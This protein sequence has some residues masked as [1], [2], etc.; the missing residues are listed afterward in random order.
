MSEPFTSF[1]AYWASITQDQ[2]I[3]FQNN[4]L[5]LQPGQYVHGWQEYLYENMGSIEHDANIHALSSQIPNVDLVGN[6]A[7]TVATPISPTSMLEE[8]TQEPLNTASANHHAPGHSTHSY[9]RANKEHRDHIASD[10]IKDLLPGDRNGTHQC[11][12]KRGRGICRRSFNSCDDAM[13]HIIEKHLKNIRFRCSCGMT[14]T[15]KA[16]AEKHK[17]KADAARAN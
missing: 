11:M 12:F 15:K 1:E 10:H 14:F 9:S 8:V 7:H 2:S 4:E 6:M 13:R 5:P 16:Y 3:A 17:I